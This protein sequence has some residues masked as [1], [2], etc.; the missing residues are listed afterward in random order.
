MAMTR[1][2]DLNKSTAALICQLFGD[3]A[4]DLVRSIGL[5]RPYS[6]QS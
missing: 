6:L 3:G 2:H 1:R 5:L 4:A